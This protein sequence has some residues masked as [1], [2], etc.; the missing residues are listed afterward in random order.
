MDRLAALTRA[1][2]GRSTAE[3]DE[4]LTEVFV[5]TDLWQRTRAGMIDVVLGPK[6]SGKSA[7]YT[8][9]LRSADELRR[10]RILVV[11][12]ES[13]ADDPI[14]SELAR[15]T[16]L[17]TRELVG[18]WKLYFLVIVAA[19]LR[20]QRVRD[21][22]VAAVVSR[23]EAE[24]LLPEPEQST[25]VEVF[26]RALRYADVQFRM[27]SEVG[28]AALP[29]DA[30]VG[31]TGT[32]TLHEPTPDEPATG[33]VSVSRLLVQLGSA[34]TGKRLQV[35]VLIDRL[36]TA[37]AAVHEDVEARALRALIQSY[38][39]LVS[40][41]Y[42]LSLKLF[43]RSDVWARI[44]ADDS[45][46][47]PGANVIETNRLEW[48]I[49]RLLDLVGRRIAHN[50]D[51]RRFLGVKHRGGARDSDTLV[52]RLLP[53][54]PSWSFPA[55]LDRLRDGNGNVAPR[56]LVRLLSE[57]RNIQVSRMEMRNE[58]YA[59]DELFEAVTLESALLRVS[60][61]RLFQVMCAEY[62]YLRQPV[63]RLAGT[64]TDHTLAG[65][66]RLWA[67]MD[68][69]AVKRIAEQLVNLGFFD[70]TALAGDVYRVA[71]LY[72]LA[73]SIR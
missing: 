58:R 49:E 14:F 47:M 48:S 17:R 63:T 50:T 62:P 22:T 37:F 11:G 19:K 26:T 56:E 57:A 44:N 18:L 54:D 61:D 52:A 53:A 27:K 20:E 71:P 28:V 45:E 55:L 59:G 32:I 21:R 24:K 67:G 7:I 16:N 70:A 33:K 9:L 51:L 35:W 23:L 3:R 65:L 25:M 30:A 12:A 8:Q 5:E 2:F 6:G 60:E 34:L 40:P 41:Q 39:D 36:D 10:H 29:V 72:R 73:L 64:G 4:L 31:V 43:L 42:R 69:D 1:D 68:T 46:R 15:A 13:P 38:I 66:E